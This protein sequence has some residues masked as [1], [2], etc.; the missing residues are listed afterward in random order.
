[1]SEYGR[2]HG[3]EPWHPQ[4]PLYGDGSWAEGR[5]DA[6][7]DSYGASYDGSYRGSYPDGSYPDA[8]GGAQQ[9]SWETYGGGPQ[10]QQHQPY[11]DGGRYQQDHQQYP[12]QHQQYPQHQEQYP[13]HRQAA[14]GR[15]WPGQGYQG[16]WDG[17]G[18][19]QHPAGPY[20]GGQG[21]Q[22]PYAAGGQ[23]GYPPPRPQQP[24]DRQPPAREHTGGY[25]FPDGGRPDVR[26]GPGPDPETGWD[27]GP[28]QGEAEFFASRDDDDEDRGSGRTA[29]RGRGAARRGRDGL[30]AD[31]ADA[32]ADGD[33][34]FGPPGDDDEDWEP[35]SRRGRDGARPAKRRGGL[36]CLVVAVVLLGSLLAA[37]YYAKQ[38]YDDRFGPPPDYA[39][40]GHGEVQVEIPEG[41]IVS[42]MGN[43]LKEAGVVK[44]VAAFTRAAEG[45]VIQPGFYVLRLE[46]SAESAVALMTDPAA[47]NTLIVPEGMRAEAIYALIDEKL[48]LEAGT[49]AQ[50]AAGGDWPLPEWAQGRPDVKDPLEGFLFPARYDVGE[51]VTPEALLSEMVGRATAKYSEYGLEEKAA[52]LGLESAYDLVTVASLVQAEGLTSEDFQ[53]MSEVIYNRLQPDNDITN[54]KL[55]FDSTFNYLRGQS[56]LKISEEE[57]HNEQ[58]PYNTYVHAGLPPGPIGSPGD[59]A[60]DASLNP[61]AEGWMFFISIDGTTTFTKT[62]EE[63][64]RLREELNE[65]LGIE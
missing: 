23:Q 19:G 57:I 28:D 29:R 13:Q 60:L 64:E 34:G 9:G 35:R 22:D 18:T 14:D 26:P 7:G 37:G 43:I 32:D 53:Q 15:G 47:L 8:Y 59:A 61:T 51:G 5:S 11:Y 3:S 36:A 27:P 56:E 24:H 6:Y 50:V 63:H 12:Q 49:T 46:M 65:Q 4:D 21:H 2:G 33:R 30:R 41:T 38:F 48:G 45:E 25:G 55:E 31:G 52:G 1:M 39:G 42:Q 10:H 17:S 44:S 54:R 58:D 16:D 62:L 40:E 20:G